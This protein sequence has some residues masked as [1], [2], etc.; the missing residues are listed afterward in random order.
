MVVLK[1]R[2]RENGKLAKTKKTKT[3][4]Q[5]ILGSDSQPIFQNEN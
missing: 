4:P 3:K 1:I 5:I 2:L